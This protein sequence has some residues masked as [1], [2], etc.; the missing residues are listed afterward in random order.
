ML[1]NNEPY[2][3]AIPRTTEAELS[4]L[5]NRA[6]GQRR[7]GGNYKGSGRP[8]SY[9]S[10]NPTRAVRALGQVYEVEGIPAP[11]KLAP[12]EVRMIREQQ[13]DSFFADI[14]IDSLLMAARFSPLCCQWVLARQRRRSTVPLVFLACAAG[15]ARIFQFAT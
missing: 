7:K 5:R 2:R 8:E 11:K 12:G 1:K 6:G 14:H 9:G 10:G 3:Y 15:S 4:K 13:L